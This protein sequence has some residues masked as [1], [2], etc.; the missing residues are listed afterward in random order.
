MGGI[1]INIWD[2]SNFF[3]SIGSQKGAK[4]ATFLQGR[5]LK[6][7]LPLVGLSFLAMVFIIASCFHYV[8]ISIYMSNQQTFT[9]CIKLSNIPN[10]WLND[11]HLLTPSHTPNLV[12][13]SHLKR[14]YKTHF[15]NF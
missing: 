2:K 3:G 5:H 11:S 13:L 15:F 12:M 6:P 14:H 7:P 1:A 9:Y 8:F 4:N 10:Y